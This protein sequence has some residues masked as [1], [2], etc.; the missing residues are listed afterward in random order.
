MIDQESETCLRQTLSQHST[1]PF[2]HHWGYEKRHSCTNKHY[3]GNLVSSITAALVRD[4]AQAG[5]S[6]HCA[7]DLGNDFH[8]D[9]FLA[10]RVAYLTF[11]EC[12][13]DFIFGGIVSLG[14]T[15]QQVSKKCFG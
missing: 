11:R 5:V 3:S 6:T 9:Q 15:M 14:A 8:F 12:L 4:G 13:L 2:S 7:L 10:H 1:A